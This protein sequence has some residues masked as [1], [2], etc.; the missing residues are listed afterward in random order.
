MSH[1]LP[2][3]D[4]LFVQAEAHSF[5]VPIIV[6]MLAG[7]P[8]RDESAQRA[9]LFW[10]HPMPM[11]YR[12]PLFRLM[13]QRYDIAYFFLR[14]N[15]AYALAAAHYSVSTNQGFALRPGTIADQDARVISAGVQ[16]ADVFVTSF[17]SNAYSVL[18]AWHAKRAGKRVVVW[19]ELNRFVPGSMRATAR[20]WWCA[21]FAR[22]VDA[23]YVLGDPQIGALRQLGVPAEKIFA[24]NECP[25]HDYSQVPGV[26][27]ELGIEAAAPVFLFLGRLIEVKGVEYLL[28][29]F[30]QVRRRHPRA[31]L[32]LAGDGPLREPLM[33]LAQE[34]KLDGVRFL[35]FV[36]DIGVKSWLMQRA[37]ALVAPSIP[38]ERVNEGGPL[39]VLEAL[40]AGLPVIGST[41][42][43][44]S[45]DKIIEGV[46]GYVVRERD[47]AALAHAMSGLLERGALNRTLVRD[48][49]VR[50][51]GHAHQAAQLQCAIEHALRRGQ[52][53]GAPSAQASA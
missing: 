52:P 33:A 50:L 16:Q 39:V 49:F 51:P 24:A 19:E 28:R 15:D 8:S 3:V 48:T 4:A 46:G 10:W 12:M 22:F 13:E 23:F 25:G 37:C 29:A 14:R 47:P 30:A 21:A 53:R 1:F 6:T 45:T 40:S 17:L 9:K 20:R 35:G 31:H 26:P 44:S 43:G 18:G 38:T 32:V 42:L 11:D 2:I 5:C 27:V 41:A 7:S 36:S 34:L